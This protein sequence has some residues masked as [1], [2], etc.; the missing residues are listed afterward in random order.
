[1]I[2]G[3]AVE[4]LQRQHQAQRY[5]PDDYANGDDLRDG[6]GERGSQQVR[7]GG[8]S[9]SGSGRSPSRRLVDGG[10]GR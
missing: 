1:M 8:R 2:D 5:R 4:Q 6:R 9:S 7:M 10:G 3:H